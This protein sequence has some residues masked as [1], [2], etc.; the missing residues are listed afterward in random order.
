MRTHRGG[1]FSTRG[2]AL[3]VLLLL[4][5]GCAAGPPP[6]GVRADPLTGLTMPMPLPDTSGWGQHVLTMQVGPNGALWVGTYG[7]G[8]FVWDRGAREWRRL[9]E[10]ENGISWGLVN[11]IAFHDSLHVWY[12]TVGNGFGYSSD[13][14]AT[15]RNWTYD[16]L[17]P[18]WQYVAPDGIVVRGDTAYIATA[19]GLRITGDGGA[20]W[21]CIQ[22]AGGVSGGA[23]PRDDGCSEHINTLP[24]KYLLSLEVERDGSIWAGHLGGLAISRD[25]G[26]S[27]TA[28]TTEGI[29]GANVRDILIAADSFGMRQWVATEQ[30]IFVDSTAK[31]ALREA[32]IR[33]P[34]Y[35]G[36]PGAP[37]ALIASPANLPPAIATS[38]GLVARMNE[39]GYRMYFVGAAD[40]FRPAGD[41]WTAVW[42]GPPYRAFGGS[43]AGI[44]RVLAGDLPF[45]AA[46]LPAPGSAPAAPRHAW[47]GRPV[48]AS[49]GNTHIDATYRYG[50]TMGGRFQQHQGV[51]LNNPA[52]TPVR[53][54]GDGVVVFAGAAE[55]GSNTVAI[56]H[57]R[58]LG[59]QHIFSTYYHNSSLDV[60]AGQRVSAGDVIARVGN[61]GRA[62]NEHLHLEVHVAPTTDSARIVDPAVRFPPHTVNPQLFI[63]PL[64][65]TGIVAGQVFDAQ[66]QPIA[67]AHIHGLLLPFPE[68]T[69]FTSAETYADQARGS[70]AYGEHFAVGDVPAGEYTLG[71][72]IGG[73][74]IWRR[75]RVEPGMVT[76]VEFRP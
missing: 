6:G 15:W 1:A 21:R 8:V 50:S 14:G 5:A 62:T 29:A 72:L 52:G 34:G 12:G 20:T 9:P 7:R 65:G 43:A 25:D 64:P 46:I 32:Q 58:R 63:E 16:E 53:A 39:G 51:E 66:G 3:A 40:R 38:Y 69:P 70:P 33:V 67:G 54:I 24:N 75:I 71:V 36:L 45:R 76:W 37:R 22:A 28:V 18:Q 13:G 27:W 48:I 26:R 47:F 42:F 41:I 56:R 60:R 74:R 61:T 55:Q 2:G 10:G 59:D 30:R 4:A 23:A 57:D 49:E 35:P 73:Q 17:G 68:E 44:N 19:D 31:A 11:S